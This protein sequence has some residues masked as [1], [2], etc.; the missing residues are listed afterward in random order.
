MRELVTAFA[1]SSQALLH[2]NEV[3]GKKGKRD[4]GIDIWQVK[5]DDARETVLE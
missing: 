3:G 4:T 5:Y 1:L 2:A